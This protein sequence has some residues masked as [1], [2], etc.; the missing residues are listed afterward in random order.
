MPAGDDVLLVSKESRQSLMRRRFD[1]AIEVQLFKHV[2]FPPDNPVATLLESLKNDLPSGINKW[3]GLDCSRFRRLYLHG[4][5]D[6]TK[7][8]SSFARAG[9]LSLC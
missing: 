5:M 4:F 9:G 7:D 2:Q 3:D 6:V 8:R 1:A